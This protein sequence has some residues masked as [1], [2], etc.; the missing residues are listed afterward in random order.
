MFLML[1]HFSY[2][3]LSFWLF[4]FTKLNSLD[5][6]NMFIQPVPAGV[7]LSPRCMN[8]PP[9]HTHTRS[10]PALCKSALKV[11]E[12]SM[13]ITSRDGCD[14]QTNCS[15]VYFVR[16]F[17]RW[18][19]QPTTT[20]SWLTLAPVALRA[21]L[22]EAWA[23]VLALPGVHPQWARCTDQ[24]VAPRGS[25]STQA[26][27]LDHSRATWGPHKDSNVPTTLRWESGGSNRLDQTLTLQLNHPYG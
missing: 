11:M 5:W 27:A 10:P 9:T 14:S 26:T 19:G 8:P 18:G 20:S 7:P 25:L 17:P 23:P 16:L 13:Y 6:M 21:W 15:F 4:S 3:I 24:A 12:L 1:E 2:L 22:L